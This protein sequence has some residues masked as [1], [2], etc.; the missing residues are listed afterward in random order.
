MYASAWLF[1]CLVVFAVGVH[2]KDATAQNNTQHLTRISTTR[3]SDDDLDI[4]LL[5]VGKPLVGVVEQGEHRYVQFGVLPKEKKFP[6]VVMYLEA[7]DEHAEVDVFCTPFHRLNDKDLPDRITAMWKS[8]EQGE[9]FISSKSI[10]YQEAV[11]TRVRNGE[12]VRV[13]KFGCAIHGMSGGSSNFQLTVNLSFDEMRIHPSHEQAMKEIHEACCSGENACH[14]WSTSELTAGDEADENDAVEYDFCHRT[15]SICNARGQLIRLDLRGYGLKCELPIESLLK[16]RTLEAL[17]LSDNDIHADISDSVTQLG[18]LRNLKDLSMEHDLITGEMDPEKVCSKLGNLRT[19]NLDHN[20]ISGEL[21]S[22]LFTESQSLEEVYLSLNHLT[23]LLVD[24]FPPSSSLKALTLSGN[25]LSGELPASFGNLKRLKVLYLDGNSFEGRIPDEF[26]GLESLEVLD[27]SNNQFSALPK[28]WMTT[29][30]P[31]RCLRMVKLQKN[32]IRGR[33]PTRLLQADALEWLDLS[34]NTFSGR[35]FAKRGMFPNLI[36]F[37]VSRNELTGPIPDQF[38]SMGLFGNEERSGP[39]HVFDVSCNNLTGAIP[40]F[41]YQEVNPNVMETDIYLEGN[42]FTCH[43]WRTLNYIPNFECSNSVTKEGTEIPTSDFFE[44]EKD[45]RNLISSRTDEDRVTINSVE[46]D[47]NTNIDGP[48]AS[49][50]DDRTGD[51][52]FGVVTAV[53]GSVILI[54]IVTLVIKFKR[55][56]ERRLGLRYGPADDIASDDGIDGDKQHREEFEQPNESVS[57]KPVRPVEP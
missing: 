23:G 1:C 53:L 15:G 14:R 38:A 33:L 54:G 37:N 48:W 45:Q 12:T 26:T 31:P 35:L 47:G 11:D 2:C 6:D 9:V 50:S 13:A 34:K 19:I 49:S 30:K 56:R 42:D 18:N 8:T 40:S 4:E 28:P 17:D 16:L 55:K 41:M 44:A 3:S 52:V 25:S 7:V 24:Q 36:H 39:Q 27:L 57:E 32:K 29:W 51:A 10:A 5:L 21:P 20:Y 22:C 43:P 46:E